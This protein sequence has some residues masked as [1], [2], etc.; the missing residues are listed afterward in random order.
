MLKAYGRDQH[1]KHKRNYVYIEINAANLHEY[2]V[3]L[4]WIFCE[5]ISTA[6]QRTQKV[7]IFPRILCMFIEL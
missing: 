1:D 3:F 5:W 2:L 7:I 6:E 4:L